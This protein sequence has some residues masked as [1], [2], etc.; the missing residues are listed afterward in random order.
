MH[1]RTT[2]KPRDLPVLSI[3][4]F[5]SADTWYSLPS[6]LN[7]FLC[8]M[9]SMADWRRHC[10][11]C[12]SLDYCLRQRGP[13]CRDN[14][15]NTGDTAHR[16]SGGAPAGGPAEGRPPR[17]ARAPPAP[18]D[19]LPGPPLRP[20]PPPFCR[21]AGALSPLRARSR[22]RAWRPGADRP[23]RP[24]PPARMRPK[25]ASRLALPS[26]HARTG[27]RLRPSCGAPT[28][29][30]R[31]ASE[32]FDQVAGLH[33]QAPCELEDRRSPRVLRAPL[34]PAD[35]RS[36]EARRA[37]ELFLRHAAFEP[38]LPDAPPERDTRGTPV[39]LFG[40]VMPGRHA[41]RP[42]PRPAGPAYE[43]IAQRRSV[44]ICADSVL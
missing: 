7:C 1:R 38:Q 8:C 9:S 34:A 36:V 19:P 20:E 26:A 43:S 28:P 32:S 14:G 29:R 24:A 4:V 25:S 2:V 5:S 23:W 30:L 21:R 39:P 15:L 37:C 42:R 27:R 17:P 3:F 41:S 16:A 11:P 12:L 22:R 33:V 10:N 6:R 44:V 35:L 40:A 13:R 18:S 31:V